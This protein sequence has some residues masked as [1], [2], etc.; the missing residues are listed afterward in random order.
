MY[1]LNLSVHRN[2]IMNFTDPES[3]DVAVMRKHRFITKFTEKGSYFQLNYV[4]RVT[5][6]HNTLGISTNLQKMQF[7]L[8]IETY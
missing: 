2:V 4:T 6:A 3:R 7:G 1:S 5:N 8:Q